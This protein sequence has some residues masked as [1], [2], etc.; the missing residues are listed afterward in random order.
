[1][2]AILILVAMGLITLVINI[3]NYPAD[4][5]M[6]VY[7]VSFMLLFMTFGNTLAT[8]FAVNLKME[9]RVLAT[10]V[11]KLFYA[12]LIF[13]IAFNKG[14]LLHFVTA[15]VFSFFINFAIVFFLSRKFVLPKLEMDI[16]LWKEISR[17]SLPLSL[18][19]IFIMV[20]TKVNILILS[21]FHGDAA[22]GFYSVADS[23][24]TYLGTIP[25]ALMTSLFPLM[26][27]YYKSSKESSIYTTLV[28]ISKL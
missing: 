4:T 3:L 22:V 21:M 13:W 14:G 2:K 5:K 1:M 26:S 25:Y 16:K 23:L 17:Y 10:L 8:I 20:Y 19:A 28:A 27:N 24:I 7:I 11:G 9:Y 18:S 15:M 12:L 6:A